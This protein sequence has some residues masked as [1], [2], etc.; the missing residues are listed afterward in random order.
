MVIDIP[1]T[2]LPLKISE[3]IACHISFSPR[4]TAPLTTCK[5]KTVKTSLHI[6]AP[7]QKKKKNLILEK[8][9]DHPEQT[10]LANI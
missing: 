5:R 1:T 9:P 8:F 6:V 10:I 2:N 4:H 7:G 3:A